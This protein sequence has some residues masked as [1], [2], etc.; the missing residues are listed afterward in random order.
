MRFFPLAVV[1]ILILAVS[2]PIAIAEEQGKKAGGGDPSMQPAGGTA[3]GKEKAG[4]PEKGARETATAKEG[5]VYLD[6]TGTGSTTGL[7]FN[8]TNKTDRRQVMIIPTGIPLTT[9]LSG[10][11]PYQTGRIPPIVLEPGETLTRE[12][13]AYSVDRNLAPAPTVASVKYALHTGPLSPQQELIRQLIVVAD[14]MEDLHTACGKV[15]EPDDLIGLTPATGTGHAPP[16]WPGRDAILLNLLQLRQDD[17]WRYEVPGELEL[18]LSGPLVIPGTINF[19]LPEA[20][21]LKANIS[22]EDEEG[23]AVFSGPT[24]KIEVK[25]EPTDNPE[26]VEF[27]IIRLEGRADPFKAL[28]KSRKDINVTLNSLEKCTGLLNINTG[29]VM[30]T[31]SFKAWGKKYKEP[32]PVAAAYTGRFD[33]PAKK[34]SL[35][36]RGT[37]FEPVK[38]EQDLYQLMRP[39][40]FWDAVHLYAIW[41]E[42]GDAG[43]K[44]LREVMTEQLLAKFPEKRAEEFADMVTK[45][46]MDKVDEVQDLQKKLEKEG[47]D[48]STLDPTLKRREKT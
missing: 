46:I 34:L 3:G 24:G 6:V 39:E 7:V 19:T 41:D 1:V 31:V 22:S 47:F 9:R 11:S 12:F 33:M 30:G 37:S 8:L 5:L 40:K 17:I 26:I 13:P 45:E 10:C 15:I 25:L 38:P 4:E 23:E 16:D 36:L 48:F 21:E 32:F 44:D 29:G 27:N 43:K 2:V 28:D 35:K 42:T 20:P 14:A 18:D